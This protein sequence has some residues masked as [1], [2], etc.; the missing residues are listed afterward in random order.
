MHASHL[1]THVNSHSAHGRIDSCTG[2]ALDTQCELGGATSNVPRPIPTCSWNVAQVCTGVPEALLQKACAIAESFKGCQHSVSMWACLPVVGE[3][4]LPAKFL[5][6][7]GSVFKRVGCTGPACTTPSQST[8]WLVQVRAGAVLQP[9]TACAFL[10]YALF[11]RSAKKSEANKAVGSTLLRFAMCA[12]SLTMDSA[13]SR[14]LRT[15][16]IMLWTALAVLM[17]L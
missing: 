11:H 8:R 13:C 17:V 6:C 9:C 10:F 16:I 14:L 4:L 15:G 3:C 7:I 2:S 5:T 1:C 12:Q